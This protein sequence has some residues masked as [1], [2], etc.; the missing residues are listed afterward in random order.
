MAAGVILDAGFAGLA[1]GGAVFARDVPAAAADGLGGVEV[2]VVGE[3]GNAE[4]EE[5]VRCGAPMVDGDLV[6]GAGGG[7]E[8]E[9][10]GGEGGG[11]VVVLGD[12]DER[13]EG[14][15]GVDLQEGVDIAAGGV[16]RDAAGAGGGP[17]PPEGA[18][19]GS[20][21]VDGL[22]GLAGGV[23]GGGTGGDGLAG[24]DARWAKSSL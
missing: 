18:V 4:E 5:A 22:A 19:A 8:G 12:R 2:V 10:A 17:R 6:A 3:E 1:G 7:V 9:F 13:G 21:G 16:E 23:V 24:E 15:A 11:L 20:A 14:G